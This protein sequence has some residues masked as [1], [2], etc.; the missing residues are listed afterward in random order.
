[1]MII[2]FIVTM[3]VIRFAHSVVNK[4]LVRFR[5]VKYDRF[6]GLVLGGL[7]GVFLCMVITFFAAMLST[8][9]RQAVL[10]SRLGN[11]ISQL[12]VQVGC[13]IPSE[14][15]KMLKTQIELFNEQ[16]DGKFTNPDDSGLQLP[17]ISFDKILENAQ[18]IKNKIE[19]KIESSQKAT[20]LIDG[21]TQWW[22]GNKTTSET[23]PETTSQNPTT[24]T[25][26]T[27]PEKQLQTKE[28][29][30]RSAPTLTSTLQEIAEQITTE[31]D[32]DQLLIPQDRGLF[33]LP[34]SPIQPS[35]FNRSQTTTQT[36]SPAK[37]FGQ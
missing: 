11:T 21:I 9:S 34:R 22:N 27:E 1:A 3:I 2:L 14:S 20:S 37:I 26:T 31:P 25:T 10:E 4:L 18:N 30:T 29:T 23:E 13:F 5:L 15:G 6:L 17:E 28:S 35:E 19:D 16:V 33:R 7:K 24:E 8:A 12:I 36:N 32:S